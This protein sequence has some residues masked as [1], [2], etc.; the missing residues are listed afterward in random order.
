MRRNKLVPLGRADLFNH[1]IVEALAFTLEP[2]LGFSELQNA[3]LDV[4][5]RR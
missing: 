1:R 2:G 5:A 3:L 4:G